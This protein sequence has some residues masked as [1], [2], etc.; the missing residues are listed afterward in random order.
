MKHDP[1]CTPLECRREEESCSIDIA[2]RWSENQTTKEHFSRLVIDRKKVLLAE[3]IIPT[4]IMER[5][6]SYCEDVGSSY[7]NLMHVHTP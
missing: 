4:G 3:R 7:Y 6:Q 2:L 5:Y 1:H